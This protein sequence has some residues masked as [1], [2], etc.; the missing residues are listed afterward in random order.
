M[1]IKNVFVMGAGVMGNG[2]AQVTAQAGYK[3][4]MSDISE[5]LVKK[6]LADIDKSLSRVVKK[7]TISDDD[8]ANI[9]SRISTA[10]NI[11]GANSCPTNF[12]LGA[13]HPIS[14]RNPTPT[15]EIL[16]K[17]IASNLLDITL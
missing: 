8:K 5:E 13:I 1:E 11:I 3:V 14:S 9:M 16:L 10:T 2:I 4:T 7:G 15:I 6:G 17:N 12:T